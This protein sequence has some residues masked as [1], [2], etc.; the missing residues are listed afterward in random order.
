M[1]GFDIIIIAMVAAFV[2]LRLR[3]ELG[4]KTG[5]E[6]TPP[7]PGQGPGGIMRPVPR[8][9]HDVAA[10]R[11]AHAQ[12]DSVVTDFTSDPVLREAYRSIREVDPSFDPA[13]FADG[14]KAAYPMILEAFWNGD[15]DT[16][17]TFLESDVFEQFSG[18]IDSR[19]DAGERVGNTL[20]RLNSGDIQSARLHG[21]TA[22]ITV[23]FKGDMRIVSRD[24]NGEIL[25]GDPDAE[26]SVTDVWTFARNTRSDDPNWQLV[27]TRSV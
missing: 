23:C 4:N 24:E 25:S 1:N 20:V 11:R 6:P 19:A 8:M 12:S 16:L 2:L 9:D 27:A 7:A 13:Q 3:S 5:N 14:A 22:E 21:A 26:V 10:D 15:K 17:K 18:V